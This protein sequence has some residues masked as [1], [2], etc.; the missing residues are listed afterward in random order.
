MKEIH[1]VADCDRI[2]TVNERGRVAVTVTDGNG[3]IELRVDGQTYPA[4]LT[5]ARARTIA[6]HLVQSAARVTKS[7]GNKAA[8]PKADSPQ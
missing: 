3:L 2:Q 6:R 1:G 5:P 7:M 4:G 8:S